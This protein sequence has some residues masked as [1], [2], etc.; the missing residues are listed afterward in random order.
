MEDEDEDIG[1]REGECDRERVEDE[2]RGSRERESVI[3]KEWKM[4]REEEKKS[5]R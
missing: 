1:G 4:K 3:E 2:E 5:G